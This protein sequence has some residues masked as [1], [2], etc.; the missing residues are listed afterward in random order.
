MAFMGWCGREGVRS[1]GEGVCWGLHNISCV[2]VKSTDEGG[3]SAGGD[4]VLRS[5]RAKSLCAP[6]R[7]GGVSPSG[8]EPLPPWAV[9]ELFERLPLTVNMGVETGQPGEGLGGDP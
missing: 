1:W 7:S 8:G 5:E 6:K 4:D 9:I 2:A 3:K